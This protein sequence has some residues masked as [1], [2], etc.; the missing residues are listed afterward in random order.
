LLRS[1]EAFQLYLTA[2]IRSDG[3]A[4]VDHAVRRR[5]H[6]LTLPLVAEVPKAESTPEAGASSTTPAKP[7][8]TGESSDAP[9]APPLSSSQQVAQAVLAT[10]MA[11]SFSLGSANLMGNKLWGAANSFTSSLSGAPGGPGGGRENPIFVS[12]SER[13]YCRGSD[14]VLCPIFLITITIAKGSVWYRIVRFVVLT[15]LGAFCKSHFRRK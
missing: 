3:S 5:E 11:N 15:S 2:L 10:R 4:S 9:P 8:N 6:V 1:D 7:S 14:P 12:I 13:E